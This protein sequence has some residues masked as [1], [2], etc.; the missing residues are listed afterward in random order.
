MD[1]SI[2]IVSWNARA[3]LQACLY[4]LHR[5]SHRHSVEIIVVDNASQDGSPDM[6]EEKFPSVRLIRNTENLGFAAANNIGIRMSAGRY[7]SL[8]NSD[9]SV[10]GSCIDALADYLDQHPDVGNVGPK[11]LNED[12]TLQSSCR[13]FPTLWNNI[14]EA[15]GLSRVF[16]RS[17]FFS[18]EHMLYFSYDR[19]LDVDVLVGCFW[20]VRRESFETVGLLDEAF[21]IY[22]EDV[23]WCKRCSKSGW[24]T[25]FFP[26][27]QAIHT[28]GGSSAND[29][30]RFAIEQQRAVLHYWKK[31]HNGFGYRGIRF[32]LFCHHLIRYLFA[33]TSHWLSPS[34]CKESD[35]RGVL[36]RACMRAILSAD[37]AEKKLSPMLETNG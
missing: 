36:C 27:G 2:V 3:F 22:A 26:E 28:R 6:V 18:G 5:C 24:R 9:V 29:P 35:L 19:I 20:M 13:R 7:I 12:M 32:V 10:L 17:S 4:S 23:D 34:K 11:L 14:C 15:I 33:S 1:I 25:S 21:F 30:L 16:G 31:H 37:T 8:I